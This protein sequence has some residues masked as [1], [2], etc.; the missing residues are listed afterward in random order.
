M[1]KASRTKGA[2]GQIYARDLLRKVWPGAYSTGLQ[3]RKTGPKPPDVEGSPFWLESKCG[4]ARIESLWS[5]LRQAEGDRI[6]AKTPKRPIAIYMRKD[7][8]TPMVCMPADEWIELAAAAFLGG[9]RG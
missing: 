5:A 8:T 4:G 7:R 6:E 1:G 3:Q 9:Y 2:R